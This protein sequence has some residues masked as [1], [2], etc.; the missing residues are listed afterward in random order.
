MLGKMITK[1]WYIIAII[2]LI[3]NLLNTL[4]A[5]YVGHWIAPI[6]AFISG[7]LLASII[8]YRSMRSMR[9][10]LNKSM[11][12]NKSMWQ[13]LRTIMKLAGVDQKLNV[14][15]EFFNGSKKN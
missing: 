7:L 4:I 14:P 2:T 15:K 6:G 8:D 9:S 13:E 10:I 5:W 11:A 3:I 12:L 1:N